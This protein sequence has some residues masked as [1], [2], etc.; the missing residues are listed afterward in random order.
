MLRAL[1]PPEICKLINS[2]F[3]MSG[4]YEI[5]VRIDKPIYINYYGEYIALKGEFGEVY[6]SDKKLVEYIIASA[7]DSSIYRFNNQI[8]EGFITTETGI[9]IGLAGEVVKENYEVKTIKNLSGLVIRIPHEIKGCSREIMPFI[10]SSN[11]INNTLII[12][13]PGCGKTTILRDICHQLS[14]EPRLYNILVADERFEIASVDRGIPRMDVGLTSD[15]ISGGDKD[16]SFSVGI[17]SLKPD[18]IVT[19]EIGSKSDA[20]AIKQASLSGVKVIATAHAETIRDLKNKVNIWDLVKNKIFERIV[21]LSSRKGIGTIEDIL[22][23][24]FVSLINLWCF[25]IFH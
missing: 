25:Y 10:V 18:V 5:R 4:V 16:F 2:R 15:V 7:T 8:K 12:S 24:E 22:D 6:Y 20:V 14:L 9:R 13:P 19:D 1:F 17:R 11:N 23:S 3:N 21:I